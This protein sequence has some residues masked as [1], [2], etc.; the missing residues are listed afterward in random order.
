MSPRRVLPAVVV[1]GTLCGAAASALAERDHSGLRARVGP[2]AAPHAMRRVDGRRS[3]Q[4]A[5]RLSEQ[6][7]VERRLRVA[8][9]V[10]RGLVALADGGFFI[11]HQSPR[12]SRFD[13]QG[14]L[15]YSLKLQAE[16]SS[17]PVVTSEGWFAF[18]AG[19]ELYMLDD[20]GKLRSRTALG[21]NDPSVRS[22]LATRDGGVLLT[23]YGFLIK[24]SAFGEVVWRR[25][26]SE[27][28]FELLETS[29]GALCVTLVGGVYRLDAAGRLSKLG[30]LGGS[31]TA[32]TA[33]ADGTQLLARTGTHRLLSFDLR[34]HRLRASV[35]DATLDLDGPVLQS[36]DGLAQV[37][38]NDGLLVRYRPD[39][40]EAQRIPVDPGSRKAPDP[41]EALMLA[42]GRLLLARDGMDVA[43]VT[44]TGEVSSIA[45]SACPDPIGI[46]AAGPKAVLLACRS[47]NMLRIE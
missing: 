29:A 19:G 17:A 39:G 6:P 36:A 12:A 33:S 28:P 9:G 14:K 32:V 1:M 7:R 25:S 10:G 37:F 8:L 46:Y 31:A 47:G 18:A 4:S 2:P 41:D 44:P 45:S 34:E 24:I 38:T 15:L 11:V 21:E 20:R 13:A 5:T 40:S 16:P 23:S 30:E 3:S 27:G 35:E 26:A 22:I 43:V 42:D